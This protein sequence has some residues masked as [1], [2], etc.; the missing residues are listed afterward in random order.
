MLRLPCGNR[1]GNAV[2]NRKTCAAGRPARFFRSPCSRSGTSA[3][4]HLRSRQMAGHPPTFDHLQAHSYARD[5]WPAEETFSSA[6]PPAGGHE[7][8]L[9]PSGRDRNVK[10][11]HPISKVKTFQICYSVGREEKTIRCAPSR[12]SLSVRTRKS[13]HKSHQ[14]P[15]RIKLNRSGQP[16]VLWHTPAALSGAVPPA[17]RAAC[18]SR[19][20]ALVSALS[21]FFS[22]STAPAAPPPSPRCSP[23]V[24]A[25]WPK[26]RK[27]RLW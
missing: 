24:R 3:L 25:R 14:R 16:R 11:D 4:C 15:L 22:L 2:C 5:S 26:P 19:R 17:A 23:A 9:R 27:A 13:P 7:P 1:T 10:T 18:G 20:S 6:R 12:I 21:C 8:I